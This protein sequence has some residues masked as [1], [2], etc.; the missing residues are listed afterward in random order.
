MVEDWFLAKFQLTHDNYTRW[1]HVDSNN[2]H[3][4]VNS[5]DRLDIEPRDL[6]TI[7]LLT[8][9]AIVTNWYPKIPFKTGAV[10]TKIFGNPPSRNDMSADWRYWDDKFDKWIWAESL[11]DANANYRKLDWWEKRTEDEM[12]THVKLTDGTIVKVLEHNFDSFY[13]ECLIEKDNRHTPILYKDCVPANAD[14]I[15]T[16]EHA[17]V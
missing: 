1:N 6:D 7:D 11:E 8:P 9:R 5:L 12:P 4:C 3:N 16:I 15:K 2:F 17:E 10:L 13:D 14:E